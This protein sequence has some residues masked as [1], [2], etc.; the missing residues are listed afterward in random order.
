MGLRSICVVYENIPNDY[1][2]EC[3]CVCVGFEMLIFKRDSGAVAIY[4]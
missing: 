1:F 4:V 2:F 3:V